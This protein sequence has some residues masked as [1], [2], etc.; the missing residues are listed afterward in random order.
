MEKLKPLP[1]DL[2]EGA[3]GFSI[4]V[5][6]APFTLDGN[7]LETKIRLEDVRL[8]T[9]DIT[10]LAGKSF[11]FPT[12]PKPG[13]IDGSVYIEGAHHPVDV[14]SIR[15]GR[16]V[17]DAI[18]AELDVRFVFEFEGLGDYRNTSL[19]LLTHLRHAAD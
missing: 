8:P 19:T 3:L 5:P 4:E 6:L 18:E 12:N 9:I 13:Y 15:F 2:R 17:R 1:G 14:R 16:T 11:L 10:K 7:I